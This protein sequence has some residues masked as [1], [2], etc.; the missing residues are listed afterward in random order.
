MF[1]PRGIL[2]PFQLHC[3]KAPRPVARRSLIFYA[4][5]GR[6]GPRDFDAF[7][8]VTAGA[9]KYLVGDFE[10]RWPSRTHTRLQVDSSNQRG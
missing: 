2:V 1:A 7:R 10:A 9:L 4:H 8:D 6:L 3:W 5:G